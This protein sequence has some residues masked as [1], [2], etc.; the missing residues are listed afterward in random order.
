M[1]TGGSEWA[2]LLKIMEQVP[3][4]RSRVSK[5]RPSFRRQ[6]RRMV[7][8]QPGSNSRPQLFREAH[9]FF[10]LAVRDRAGHFVVELISFG[11]EAVESLLD[12][13]IL[14]SI[15]RDSITL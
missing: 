4:Q 15:S 14:E 13:F 2:M 8:F 12:C 5:E 6:Q 1:V 3:G 9:H 11:S 10:D 7:S